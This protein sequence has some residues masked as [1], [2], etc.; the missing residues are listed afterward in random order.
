MG[1]LNLFICQGGL[2]YLLFI[3][4]I[5]H[6]VFILQMGANQTVSRTSEAADVLASTIGTDTVTA[7][8]RPSVYDSCCQTDVKP[9]STGTTFR[10]FTSDHS[11]NTN[12]LSAESKLYLYEQI[13]IGISVSTIML[14]ILFIVIILFYWRKYKMQN[15]E[16]ENIEF[17]FDSMRSIETRL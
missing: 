15:R 7:N 6:Y 3:L 4:L 9:H 16:Y 2:V 1:H 12:V 14:L 13:I 11:S 5:F 17:E 10:L 8:F